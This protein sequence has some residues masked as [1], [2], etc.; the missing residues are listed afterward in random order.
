MITI[1][2]FPIKVCPFCG[3]KFDFRD[4]I[5]RNDFFAGC[6]HT[7]PDCGMK[8]QYVTE[9]EILKVVDDL[10]RYHTRGA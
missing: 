7:C 5:N 3:H 2:D 4:H 1:S 6:A 10:R 9:S 8:F